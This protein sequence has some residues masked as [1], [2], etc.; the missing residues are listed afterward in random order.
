MHFE[1]RIVD[2]MAEGFFADFAEANA[3]VTIDARAEISFGI[4][5]VE[6]EDLVEADEFFDLADGVVPAFLGAQIESGFEEV[7]GVEADSKAALVF[8]ALKNFTE[9]L[10]AVAEAAS[11]SGG[12][13]ERDADGG[14]FGYREDFVEAGD[15]VF[16]ARFFACA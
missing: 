14:C 3:G 16:D 2:D 8:D 11:L 4:V 13:F 12:V 9:M 10:D 5:D 6:G 15:D 7:R 1:A